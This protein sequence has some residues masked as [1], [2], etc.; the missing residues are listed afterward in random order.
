MLPV[1]RS[2]GH[3][4]S[5]HFFGGSLSTW[6][7]LR[8]TAHS[9][10]V[11]TAVGLI[12]LFLCPLARPARI[13]PCCAACLA[14][15]VRKLSWLPRLVVWLSW[16]PCL[17]LVHSLHSWRK[18]E[19]S[20][21]LSGAHISLALYVPAIWKLASPSVAFHACR[22]SLSDLFQFTCFV[23]SWLCFCVHGCVFTCV[24]C[25][26]VR[27]HAVCLCVRSNI[28]SWIRQA[29]PALCSA[30]CAVFPFK[31]GRLA[32]VGSLGFSCCQLS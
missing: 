21:H 5:C 12:S 28:G 22:L 19:N 11:R 31:S 18:N 7:F 17:E 27:V 26:C 32:H 14:L 2:S 4:D 3:W 6:P 29:C 13:N 8:R 24:R 15:T 1:S 10:S 25:M 30:L 20:L 23:D 16:F 9:T